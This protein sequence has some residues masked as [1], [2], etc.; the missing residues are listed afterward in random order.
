MEN[1]HP[2]NRKKNRRLHQPEEA[3]LLSASVCYL[4]DGHYYHLPS[5][6]SPR[7]MLFSDMLL[8]FTCPDKYGSAQLQGDQ[9]EFVA[10]QPDN[11]Y[12]VICTLTGIVKKKGDDSDSA[13][14]AYIYRKGT[15]LPVFRCEFSENKDEY[16]FLMACKEFPAGDYFILFDGI[17]ESAR[18]CSELEDMEGMP[19]FHFTI[20]EHGKGLSH[21]KFIHQPLD[22]LPLLKLRTVSGSLN[23]CDEYRYV[24]YNRVYRPIFHRTCTPDA[25]GLVLTLMELSYPLDDIYTL[26]L[27]HNN[28]PFL[29]YRY[30]LLDKRAHHLTTIPLDEGCP[31]YALAGPLSHHIHEDKFALE[32]G[33]LP[34]K[35]YILEVL[36]D[37]KEK[38]NLMVF[39]PALPSPAFI[40]G[41][42]ELLH[43]RGNYTVIDAAEIAAIWRNNRSVNLHRL[44]KEEGIVLQNLSVLLQRDYRALFNLLDIHMKT[45]GK[46]FYLFDLAD[47]MTRFLSGLKHS[48]NCF[49]DDHRLLVPDYEPADQVYMVDCALMEHMYKMDGKSLCRLN[50]LI[51]MEEELFC[52]MDR[53]SLNDWV[54]NRIV[55]YLEEQPDDESVN[56]SG[57]DVVRIDFDVVGLP[58]M[59]D[60]T[61]ERCLADLYDMVGL[62]HL[63]S[64]L[65]TLFN[66]AKFDRMRCNM[67]LPE[68]NEKRCHMIFTGN[69]G[70]GKTT[71]ARIMGKVFKE[72]GILSNGEVITAERADMVGKY[73]GHT[74][75]MMKELLERAKGNVL[76]I[77]EAYSLC[78]SS[79]GDRIDFGNRV[80]ESLLGVLAENDSDM[81]I[82]M[83][84]Y[85]KEIMQMLDKNPGLRGRFAYT[86]HFEDYT[87]DQL[88]E[89]C[90]NKLNEKM[91][92]VEDPVQDVMKSCIS[93]AI[94]AKDA[95][96][97]N[98]RWAEQFAMQG[99]VSA[100]ADRL[101]QPSMQL[102]IEDLCMVTEADVLAGY[103]MTRPASK[104]SHRPVGF[105]NG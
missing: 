60:G 25:N 82:I 40:T 83:A 77:D 100:M 72:L 33:F 63:K 9:H 45:S 95:L 28:E 91:F 12:H 32:P 2:N 75:D 24:C 81:I 46:T 90:L 55:P 97:H 62:D 102:E 34:V 10:L 22:D 51:M 74:E 54:N 53:S 6:S 79:S 14:T 27:Y 70:T 104:F 78:D 87:A 80:I 18:S 41:T 58:E 105:R 65:T 23:R 7:D 1:N 4:H 39:C 30:T 43:G 29:A 50:D 92:R 57:W 52:S 36:S 89:I 94:A 15:P 69:P 44:M 5:S 85:E 3:P 11:V 8:S 88:L 101:C 42:M 66:R 73:I 84:G 16:M 13:P 17:E 68:L 61:Y 47:V 26:V 56:E 76:F 20:K 48:A 49:A 19:T 67:G 38:G 21:P 99:I 35:D 31:V 59:P 93:S 103:E 37:V 98:A 64:R 86:F 71:V 96:F